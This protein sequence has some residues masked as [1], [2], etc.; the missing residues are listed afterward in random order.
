MIG[1]FQHLIGSGKRIDVP[2]SCAFVISSDYFGRATHAQDLIALNSA[3]GKA[4]RALPEW[5]SGTLTTFIQC[6][7]LSTAANSALAYL[8]QRHQRQ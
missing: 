7:G 6:S 3:T 1:V 5:I 2:R 4:F 8:F